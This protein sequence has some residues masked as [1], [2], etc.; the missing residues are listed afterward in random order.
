MLLTTVPRYVPN[1]FC[2]SRPYP[3]SSYYKCRLL[4]GWRDTTHPISTEVFDVAGE[5]GLSA[6]GDGDVV[7]DADE[8]RP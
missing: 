3:K 6:D 1:L 4:N 7:D 8:F 2:Y 5:D